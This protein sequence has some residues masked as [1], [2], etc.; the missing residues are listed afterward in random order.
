MDATQIQR[1]ARQL[2][3]MQGAKAIAEAAHKAQAF[4]EQR[5]RA[6]RDLAAHRGG[7]ARTARPAPLLSAATAQGRTAGLSSVS[8]RA[9]HIR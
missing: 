9:R 8:P 6:S 2:Y 3:E 5:Q 7:A 4:E 1:Y